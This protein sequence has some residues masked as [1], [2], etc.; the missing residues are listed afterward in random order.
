MLAVIHS[1][2]YPTRSNLDFYHSKNGLSGFDTPNIVSLI[3]LPLCQFILC[4]IALKIV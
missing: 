4:I 3:S 1:H 2:T